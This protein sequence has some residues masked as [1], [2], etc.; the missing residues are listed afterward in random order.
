MVEIAAVTQG[1]AHLRSTGNTVTRGLLVVPLTLVVLLLAVP[2]AVLPFTRHRGYV[3]R[4][5]QAL[6]AV[7]T[8]ITAGPT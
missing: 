1:V 5:L 7:V 6:T 8:A 2:I 4:L 3:L